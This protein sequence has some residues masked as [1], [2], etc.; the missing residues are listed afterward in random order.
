MAT[1]FGHGPVYIDTLTQPGDLVF[2]PFCGGG[3]TAVAAALAHRRWI[4]CDVDEQAV[5][6]A[7][8]RLREASA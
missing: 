7:R 1:G 4:T 6:I 3:T 5:W 8:Q 2:D